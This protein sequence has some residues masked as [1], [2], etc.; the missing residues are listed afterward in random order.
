MDVVDNITAK[1]KANNGGAMQIFISFHFNTR[2]PL[3]SIKNPRRLL[4]AGGGFL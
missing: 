4:R 2:V 3:S 1:Q